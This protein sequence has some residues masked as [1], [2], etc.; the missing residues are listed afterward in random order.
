MRPQQMVLMLG[1][2]TETRKLFK[3]VE[4]KR[5]KKF[6]F[7]LPLFPMVEIPNKGFGSLSFYS[8]VILLICSWL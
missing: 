3:K 1:R 6:Y 5:T 7:T 2:K 8:S 4:H